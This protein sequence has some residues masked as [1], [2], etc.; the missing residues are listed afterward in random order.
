MCA[1]FIRLYLQINGSQEVDHPDDYAA[2]HAV[3]AAGHDRRR[4]WLCPC[5][6]ACGTWRPCRFARA[7]PVGQW[8]WLWLKQSSSLVSPPSTC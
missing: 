2:E 1:R 8:L 4:R 6:I 3:R 7:S 5:A